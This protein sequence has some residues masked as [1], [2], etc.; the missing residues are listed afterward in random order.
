MNLCKTL[1]GQLDICACVLQ[2]ATYIGNNQVQQWV[3]IICAAGQSLVRGGGYQGGHEGCGGCLRPMALCTLSL[4]TYSLCI[5]VFCV[6]RLMCWGVGEW[7]SGGDTWR[8]GRLG[9]TRCS[10]PSPRQ[11]SLIFESLWGGR[12]RYFLLTIH[13]VWIFEIHICM[14]LNMDAHFGRWHGPVE[15]KT[16]NFDL[17]R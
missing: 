1:G 7:T 11:T 2:C 14:I 4:C 5:C 16:N 10:P 6:K 15:Q 8:A 3:D 17:E 13:L 9:Y 12:L